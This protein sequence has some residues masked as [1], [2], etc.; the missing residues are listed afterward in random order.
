MPIYENLAASGSGAT[1]SKYHQIKV[2]CIVTLLDVY[3][4]SN[5]VSVET[6]PSAGPVKMATVESGANAALSKAVIEEYNQSEETVYYGDPSVLPSSKCSWH[7]SSI[8]SFLITLAL[9]LLTH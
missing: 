2:K 9:L 8:F 5:E 4:K 1:G 6:E 7:I 3:H